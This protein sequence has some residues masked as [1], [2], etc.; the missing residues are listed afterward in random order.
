MQLLYYLASTGR[1]PFA[2]W[3][4][5][6]A[7]DAAARVA[8]ALKRMQQGNLSN[9]KAVGEGVL[10]LR[11]NFGPGY[12][13]YFGYDGKTLVILLSGG[14]KR[15]QQRDIETAKKQWSDYKKRKTDR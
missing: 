7:P 9:A 3:F 1:S 8:I 15:R 5:S 13:I 2:E 10:E 6:L 14:T 12:R 4:D 11:I